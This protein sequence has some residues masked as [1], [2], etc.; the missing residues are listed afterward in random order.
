MFSYFTETAISSD[1]VQFP[2]KANSSCLPGQFQCSSRAFQSDVTPNPNSVQD[3]GAPLYAHLG[4]DKT[5]NGLAGGRSPRSSDKPDKSEALCIE[6]T[7]VCDNVSDCPDNSDEAL[8]NINECEDHNVCSQTCRDLKVGYQCLCFPHYRVNP[9][10]PRLCQDIDECQETHP[11]PQVCRN[12]I[13]SYQCSCAPGYIEEQDGHVCRANSTIRPHL[14]LSNRYHI[15]EI[16]IHGNYNRTVVSNL[17]NA[18]GLDFDWADGCI[19]WSDVANHSSSIRR[20]CGKNET[21]VIQSS[22]QSPDGIALDWVARNLYWCDKGLD[23]I[24]V[25]K[26]NGSFRKVLISKGLSE[27]RAIVLDPY[28]GYLY[29]SDWGEKAHIGK[30]GMDGS[31]PHVLFNGTLG[32]P[33]ALTIDYAS[34]TLFWADA[35]KDYIAMADL[36]ANNFKYILSKRSPQA[37]VQHIFALT[38]FEDWLYWTDWKEKSVLKAHKFTG[39]NIT[40]V[41][42]AINRPMDIHIYHPLRQMPLPGPNPCADNGGCS[43]LCLLTPGGGSVCDCPNSFKLDVDKKSCAPDCPAHFVCEEAY[44]CIPFWWKCD[45]Q[46]DCGDGSDE[47]ENCPPFRCNLGQLQCN[48]TSSSGNSTCLHPAQIC[49]GS[50]QCEDGSDE[51][52]CD[53]YMCLSNQFKC[54]PSSSSNGLCIDKSKLCDGASDCPGGEDESDCHPKPCPD[55]KFACVNNALCIPTVW[56]CDGQKDCADGSDEPANCFNRTCP[57]DL[58]KCNS[59]GQCLPKRWVCDGEVDCKDKEDEQQDCHLSL[60]CDANEF[61]CGNNVCIPLDFRCDGV[62]DCTDGS[63]EDDACRVTA[64]QC[65]LEEYSCGSHD[66]CVALSLVCNG[67]RD[68]SDGSDELFCHGHVACKN[69]YVHCNS[70][71]ECIL[72]EWVCDRDVDCPD[73]SDEH[74]CSCQGNHERCGDN[75]C[76]PS[77][78]FCDGEKDCSNGTDED[79]K[80]CAQREC[81]H[82]RFRCNNS[83]C[84]QD[85]KRCD[86][87]QHC[88]DGSD[89]DPVL[90]AGVHDDHHA[91]CGDGQFRCSN[92]HCISHSLVC[93]SFNDCFDN[94]D[95][96]DCDSSVCSFGTCSQ[97]CIPKKKTNA[98]CY[99]DTNYMLFTSD[100][101]RQSCVAKGGL[102]YLLVAEDSRLLRLGIHHQPNS[103]GSYDSQEFDQGDSVPEGRV[104][105]VDVLYFSTLSQYPI[106]YWTNLATGSLRGTLLTPSDASTSP[107][108]DRQKDSPTGATEKQSDEKQPEG[109][110]GENSTSDG[111]TNTSAG[112]D[113]GFPKKRVHRDVFAEP[114]GVL[115][116]GLTEPRGVAV[117]WIGGWV[118]IGCR[119]SI[120]AVSTDGSTLVTILKAKN[121]RPYDLVLDPSY[122]RM[123][124]TVVTNQ[125]SHRSSAG[126]EMSLMNGRERN[127]LLTRESHW[128]SGL[129]IDYPAKRL[130]WTDL[131]LRAIFTTKLDGSDKHLVKSLSAGY[132]HLNKLSVFEDYLYFSMSRGHRV[133]R[134]HKFG[135][136]AHNLTLLAQ[137][138]LDVT[139]I[140]IL[141]ENSQNRNIS[142]PCASNPC[143]LGQACFL[144]GSG[145]HSCLCPRL[146]NSTECGGTGP[147]GGPCGN[148]TCVST[149][150]SHSCQCLPGY[151]GKFCQFFKCLD[152]CKHGT[153][154]ESAS[155]N[156][157]CECDGGWEGERCDV[158]QCNG[159]D[160]H[161]DNTAQVECTPPCRNNGYCVQASGSGKRFCRCPPGYHGRSCEN[162]SC[163]PNQK[164]FCG[165]K[166]ACSLKLGEPE[167]TCLPGYSGD[168]CQHSN[169]DSYCIHGYCT[170]EKDGRP[171]CSCSWGYSG[172]RCEHNSTLATVTDCD[173]VHCNNGGTCHRTAQGGECQCPVG[174]SGDTCEERTGS[175]EDFCAGV[176]CKHGGWCKVEFGVGKCRCPEKWVGEDCGVQR[177]CKARCFNGGTCIVNPDPSLAPECLCPVGFYGLRCEARSQ[178][179]DDTSFLPDWHESHYTAAIVSTIVT[180]GL[181]LTVVLLGVWWKCRRSR[182]GIEHVRLKDTSGAGTVE[183]TN[184]IFMAQGAHHD[185]EPVFTLQDTRQNGSGGGGTFKNP[186]YDSLYERNEDGSGALEERAG[187]LASADPLG[188][189]DSPNPDDAKPRL[190]RLRIVGEIFYCKVDVSTLCLVVSR[191]GSTHKMEYKSKCNS[192]SPSQ[193]R[194][195]HLNRRRN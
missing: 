52:D 126:I 172:D 120:V 115:V 157:T 40:K 104:E 84:I 129:A 65:D 87:E 165:D 35:N 91:W 22:V 80:Y 150:G 143:P 167:C 38:V 182:R 146:S 95:E 106:A 188:V 15:R 137:Y 29:W 139:H 178:S 155:G 186:V 145:E 43:T 54:P 134:I 39:A 20:K 159:S 107:P 152:V 153:C 176:V 174:Y 17:T 171:K 8:C 185:D 81:P 163:F 149:E 78:W 47:P 85:Y 42:R 49:D 31:N 160:C 53:V 169:C 130:Y 19:Y 116:S 132:D 90:C 103:V 66:Q 190:S 105:S 173:G 177:T 168:R 21:E 192:R 135:G 109:D 11:C 195:A 76:L 100:K 5:R 46:D 30:A 154:I 121:L 73:G 123:Y 12:L 184:P 191:A 128:P 144:A 18:V 72:S 161:G 112:G 170:L 1:T 119:D 7:R 108:P 142:N 189:T 83:I 93:D 55:D 183:L 181:L 56:M 57:Q 61:R 101:K 180:L 59:S 124:W 118:Y 136:R 193:L 60:P 125:F 88:S 79:P 50:A 166:G 34:H 133:Y 26:L 102:P 97:I 75:V 89:E 6:E 25:S 67:Q 32:W 13:G 41:Y 187:L 62:N 86:G 147:C 162:D 138:P 10:E 127:W 37:Y 82:G 48:A 64:K 23:A 77:S 117:D 14:L 194:R 45:T 96:Q 3:P 122:G 63:D 111:F 175:Q 70:S 114:T 2:S 113:A 16:G 9:A 68:C 28:R 24:E 99:C 156:T 69:D 94:S 33:N 110:L 44:R 148:G 36:D 131:K 27:P 74:N 92:S 164:S 158:D 179:L 151:H 4:G 140:T 71:G 51:R 141:Q 58:F 98:T